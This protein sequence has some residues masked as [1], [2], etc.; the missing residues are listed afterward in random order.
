M[1]S[2]R[3]CRQLDSMLNIKEKFNIWKENA[4]R[5]EAVVT[6]GKP[7]TELSMNV[8]TW[9]WSNF[10]SSAMTCAAAPFLSFL[11]TTVMYRNATIHSV[12]TISYRNHYQFA[13]GHDSKVKSRAS[14]LPLERHSQM[15]RHYLRAIITLC[16]DLVHSLR[17][18]EY[19]LKDLA[20]SADCSRWQCPR[21][22]ASNR[23]DSEP[24]R[25]WLQPVLRQ[26][27]AQVVPVLSSSQV[28]RTEGPYLQ[29]TSNL[30][31]ANSQRCTLDSNVHNSS[32]MK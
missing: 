10:K 19:L 11:K 21:V 29:P 5:I 12:H 7:G 6:V 2:S 22:C 4:R 18:N 15:E 3:S 32:D 25:K 8:A 28:V 14:T 30:L 27:V 16:N 26:A 1:P 17:I 23:L 24:T 31:L 13:W 9:Y 20:F